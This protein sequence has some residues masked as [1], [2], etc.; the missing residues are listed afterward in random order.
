MP[1]NRDGWAQKAAGELFDCLELGPSVGG[2]NYN[3]V[4]A[5]LE[6]RKYEDQA[7]V[8]KTRIEAAEAAKETAGYTRQSAR[9][10]SSSVI[11]VSVTAAASAYPLQT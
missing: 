3:R 5:E 6:C 10:M 2:A 9:A 8:Y 11:A 7:A 1:P 4:L